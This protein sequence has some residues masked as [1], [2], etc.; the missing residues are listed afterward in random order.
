MWK[1]IV[2]II[3]LQKILKISQLLEMLLIYWDWEKIHNVTVP[4]CYICW[5]SPFHA[6]Q[7]LEISSPSELPWSVD[8]LSQITL[9]CSK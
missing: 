2:K 8:L 1:I 6:S 9:L 7:F 3:A 5:R 4:S